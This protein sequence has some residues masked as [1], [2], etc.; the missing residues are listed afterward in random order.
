MNTAL[1]VAAGVVSAYLLVV[2]VRLGAHQR[3]PLAFGP[4]SLERI[5]DRAARR[6]ADQPLFT[7]D[8]PVSW[9]V[10]AHAGRYADDRA[11]SA[12]RV[13]ST[14]GHLATMLREKLALGAG[15]RVAVLKQ[16]H[17]D[18]HLLM[19]GIVRAGGIACPV[20]GG[21]AAADLEPYLASLGATILLTDSATLGRL[22]REGAGFGSVTTIVLAE[23]KAGATARD[24]ETLRIWAARVGPP[25]RVVWLEEA[26]G[27]AGQESAAVPRGTRDAVYL[28]HS[29][30]TTGFPKAVV[31]RN[32]AQSHAVRGWLCYVHLSR[33]CDRG[34]VAVPNNH[35]AVIL[36]F[37]SALLL[38]L[39]THWDSSYGLADFD[40]ARVVSA[41]ARGRFSGYFGF[42][43][44]YTKM[45]E[46]D[47]AA[48]DLSAMRVWASTADASHAAIV[49]SFVAVG[50]AFRSIGIPIDGSVYLD[51]QG[52]S[53]VGTP[54]VLRYVTRFTKKFDRRIGKPGSTPFGPAVRIARDGVVVR[55]GEAGR[56]EVKGRTVLDAY[57]NN[58]AM[59]QE[60]IRDGWFFTGDVARQEQDGHLIQLDREVDV[61][62]TAH[63]PVY[64]LLIE[65]EIHRHPAVFD[66]CVYG[67][68]QL[69][70]A[71]SPA[72]AVALRPG[73]AITAADLRTLVNARL[74]AGEQ[75]TRLD[76]IEWSEFP[77]GLTGKTLKRVFRDRT[78]RCLHTGQV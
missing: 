71:Q 12:E 18:V 1:A 51:A 25:A 27:A 41:L 22:V 52:S 3:L 50:G 61:I 57:W 60:A 67:E 24:A 36:T 19:A 42:P 59:T 15:E 66:A 68:R 47:L 16:N 40:P 70:G 11:W 26:L 62:H 37:N 54:S 56:L 2:A 78:E 10:P 32:G 4:I 46:V 58:E 23:P 35:Q 8:C 53:E 72:A 21:F 64:S 63:G 69:D 43:I 38:G 20:N 28:V 14:A 6:Y 31:L 9:R 55:R 5:P 39:P 48:H 76:V 75:L 17:F 29:S 44:T 65:E 73:S 74:G 34:Y 13:R 7:C 30:G 45:K 77:I 33:T 49:R